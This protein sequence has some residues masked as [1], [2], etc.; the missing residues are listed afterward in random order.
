MTKQAPDQAER[1][2]FLAER[3]RSFFLKAGAGAGKSTSLVERIMHT[4]ADPAS[5]VRISNIV[6]IT[7]TNRAA[8]DLTHKLRAELVKKA[9]DG[10]SDP[11]A[12]AL[13]DLDTAHVGTIHSFAG[14]I[15]KRFALE[16]GLPPG[17]EVA[18]ESESAVA[19]R[20]RA[21][22][23]VESLSNLA[24]IES[25]L[26]RYGIPMGAV[27]AA[28]E[29]LDR[30]SGRIESDACARAAAQ[31]AQ[32]AQEARLALAAGIDQ[33]VG[34]C[35]NEDDKLMQVIAGHRATSRWSGPQSDPGVLA[36]PGGH[37]RGVC[38]AGVG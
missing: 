38:P 1:A 26:G 2:R 20:S 30:V 13:R 12:R 19:L 6:A 24:T 25:V 34:L 5:G 28:I 15:L 22:A 21:R 17:F 29:D 14:A 7:F 37:P 10:S 16:A 23:A 9:G 3:D 31:D 33:I 35:R 18:T 32:Q 8:A 27:V 4:I 11:Y 36:R